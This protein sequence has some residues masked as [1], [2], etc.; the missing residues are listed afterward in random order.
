VTVP[1]VAASDGRDERTASAAVVGS[2]VT[3]TSSSAA[4][5]AVTAQPRSATTITRDYSRGTR[6]ADPF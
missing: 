1:G 3:S 4:T 6:V 2:V 5:A